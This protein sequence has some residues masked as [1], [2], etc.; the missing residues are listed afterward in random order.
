MEDPFQFSK[1]GSRS[2]FLRKKGHFL[3]KNILS[4]RTFQNFVYTMI[5]LF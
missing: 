4:H 1:I 3:I 2:H 5:A